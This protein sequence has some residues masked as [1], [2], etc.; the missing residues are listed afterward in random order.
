MYG[1]D[2]GK[3]T[4]FVTPGVTT[5][6]LSFLSS[7]TCGLAFIGEKKDGMV[8]RTI[9]A[10]VKKLEIMLAHLVT[11]FSVLI[12]QTTIAFLAMFLLFSIP[13]LGSIPL[14]FVLVTLNGVAGMSL[15][16]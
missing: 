14:A 7:L 12:V 1:E 6:F 16:E 15:G 5:A 9:V 4:N 13:H 2:G 11:Q 8:H 3:I 10:G